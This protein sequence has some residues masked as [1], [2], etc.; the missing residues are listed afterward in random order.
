MKFDSMKL[1]LLIPILI[2]LS[3]FIINH[4]ME[5]KE[6]GEWNRIYGIIGVA[7]DILKIENG[8]LVTGRC[9]PKEKEY[10]DVFLLKIDKNGNEIWNKTYGGW[11]GR[12][13]KEDY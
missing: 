12:C 8:Y 3:A 1:A 6:N 7:Y 4:P 2:L 9:Q 11:G 5:E 13:G 10:F